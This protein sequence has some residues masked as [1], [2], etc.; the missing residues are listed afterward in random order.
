MREIFKD[1]VRYKIRNGQE[2]AVET[3]ELNFSPPR[4]RNKA[5]DFAM[6]PLEWAARAAEATKT[7]EL[8]ICCYTGST[9]RP[10]NRR[11]R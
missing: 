10:E 6:V 5:D 2:I 11:A 1:G 4:R 7:P 3:M 8:L 9:R